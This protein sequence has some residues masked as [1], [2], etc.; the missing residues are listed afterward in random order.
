MGQMWPCRVGGCFAPLVVEPPGELA[1]TI[2][3]ILQILAAI[4]DV[5]LNKVTHIL[6]ATLAMR[7][8]WG[9]CTGSLT[10]QSKDL[11]LRLTKL[12]KA[13]GNSSSPVPPAQTQPQE[14]DQRSLFLQ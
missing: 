5:I 3:Y 2:Y 12:T 8:T 9:K 4:G 1:G 7:L 6:H 13:P 10:E 11:F 14:G